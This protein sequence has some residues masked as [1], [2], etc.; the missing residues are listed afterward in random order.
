M[1]SSDTAKKDIA[2]SATN[3]TILVTG[4]VHGVFVILSLG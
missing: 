2:L 1:V 3:F 4:N